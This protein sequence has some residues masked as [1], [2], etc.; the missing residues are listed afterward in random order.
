MVM[1]DKSEALTLF[2][3]AYKTGH[4]VQYP[5]GVTEINVNFTPRNTKYLNRSIATDG[6]LVVYGL[7][8][9]LKT[10]KTIFDC[11]FESDIELAIANYK[12]TCDSLLGKDVVD[13]TPWKQ[14]HDLGYMPLEFRV[15][16]EGTLIKEGTPVLTMHNTHPDF[17]WL[18]NYI[19]VLLTVLLWKP[20]TIANIAREYR[21][22]GEYWAEKTGCPKE[23]VDYQFHDF[24]MR[25]SACIEDAY[26][27]GRAWLQYFKGSD[28]IFACATLGDD[29]PRGFSSVPATEHSVMCCGSQ[30]NEFETYKRLLTETYPSGIL[31]IVSDTWDY[32][33]VLTD[34]LP[35]LKD[36]ILGRE[37]KLVI[38]PD[39]G[40]PFDIVCGT[41]H[42]YLAD[43]K[44]DLEEEAHRLFEEFYAFEVSST[45]GFIF[46]VVHGKEYFQVEGWVS[47][48]GNEDEPEYTL[49]IIRKIE[50]TPEEKG[51]IL[52]LWELSVEV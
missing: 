6:R 52:L 1:L 15:L 18:P 47:S 37:G 9:G 42:F 20:F 23:F 13:M 40:N 35:R 36:T 21:L 2:A 7:K 45:G 14:L 27:V 43:E 31:S 19:E 17:Y 26:H 28:N 33:Q 51:S 49:S 48:F 39:S 32:F 22:L 34:F 38:R 3:D 41:K 5:S 12:K 44:Y 4:R 50:P 16:P 10:L 29:A 25:G 30:E 24:S 8:S 11:F 46:N